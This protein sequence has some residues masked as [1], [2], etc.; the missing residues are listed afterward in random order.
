MRWRFL[1][2]LR[3]GNKRGEMAKVSIDDQIR[4]AQRELDMRQR[5]YPNWVRNGKM[6]AA[7]AVKEIAAMLSIID[8]LRWAKKIAEKKM[9]YIANQEPIDNDE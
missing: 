9:E 3:R 1:R 7:S 5:V 4:S 8:T 6:T 2:E